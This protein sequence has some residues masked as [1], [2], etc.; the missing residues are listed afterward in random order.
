MDDNFL[1]KK[2][3]CG[4]GPTERFLFGLVGK[5]LLCQKCYNRTDDWEL[6]PCVCGDLGWY[7]L[8][9]R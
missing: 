5:S 6:E 2:V 7:L 1:I 9:D 8:R 4:T 3:F